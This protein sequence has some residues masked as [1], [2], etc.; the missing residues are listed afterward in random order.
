[1]K[2]RIFISVL[3]LLSLLFT[4]CGVDTG[5]NKESR[6]INNNKNEWNGW[7]FFS[8]PF[9][10][11]ER[12]NP[13]NENSR[14]VERT[15]YRLMMENTETGEKKS[16]CIIPD[17][18][19]SV[20]SGCLFVSRYNFL[21]TYVVGDYL[22]LYCNG[23]FY[24]LNADDAKDRSKSGFYHELR[25]I[26]IV[27]GKSGSVFS[28]IAG[29][30]S[31]DYLVGDRYVWY[32]LPDIVEKEPVY[33]L[34][35]FDYLKSQTL[36][37]A[38]FDDMSSL[39]LL[40]DSRIYIGRHSLSVASP[41]DLN[42]ISLD[43]DGKNRKEEPSLIASRWLL[44]GSYLLSRDIIAIPGG[45]TM[46]VSPHFTYYN[47]ATKEKH[48]FS[49]G[50]NVN[51]IGFRETDGRIYYISSKK[52][53]IVFTL[54]AFT[55]A[56]ELVMTVDEFMNNE[57][58]I[59]K[60]GDEIQD[61]LFNDTMFLKSRNPDGSDPRTHFEFP[62]GMFF[63]GIDDPRYSNMDTGS[64]SKDG[65]LFYVEIASKKDGKT[66]RNNASINIDTGEINY[67]QD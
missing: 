38:A 31:S 19:H 59:K 43:Y 30:T 45:L 2:K 12:A 42:V 24:P 66:V 60:M 47:I 49:E 14:V 11:S 21:D 61:A 4:S 55:R 54:N 51:A 32:V 35:R 9:Q 13:D 17:C 15:G 50:E 57:S 25:Y 58:E 37:L 67:I 44:N 46:C 26:N 39:Y 8:E 29:Y 41:D 40:T 6:I 48:D 33:K 36:D 18:D 5:E 65:R 34:F 63:E 23:Q 3:I 27:S 16:P 53:E 7:T 20:D 22:F 62:P 1:M 10:F 56:A 64:I 52:A 28:Y